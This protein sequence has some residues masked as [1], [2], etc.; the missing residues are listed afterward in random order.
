MR[1]HKMKAETQICPVCNLPIEIRY[2][3][4]ER[5]KLF[6]VGD[7]DDAAE[8]FAEN[9]HRL[10]HWYELFGQAEPLA[11][12]IACCPRCKTFYHRACWLKIKKLSD[13]TLSA[14]AHCGC[15]KAV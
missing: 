14:T 13:S 6:T 11:D 8:I 1:E 9:D 10:A 5:P 7:E 12:G 2:I 15:M 3:P 4:R